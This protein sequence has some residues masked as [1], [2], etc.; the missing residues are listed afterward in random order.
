MRKTHEEKNNQKGRKVHCLQNQVFHMFFEPMG[1][2]G[3]LA[4][5]F[6]RFGTW[7]EI[8]WTAQKK[9]K[10]INK[11]ENT[12][13]KS[14]NKKQTCN[15]KNLYLKNLFLKNRIL[16]NMF[17]KNMFLKNLYLKNLFVKNLFLKNLYLKNL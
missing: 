9:K 7:W 12:T 1:L 5:F 2:G 6:G 13:I 15:W 14:T 16:K 3:T 11:E 17:L 10:N 8:Q 4:I